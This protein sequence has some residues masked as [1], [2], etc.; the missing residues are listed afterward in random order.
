LKIFQEVDIVED[1][2]IEIRAPQN[3]WRQK[4]KPI[5]SIVVYK[6]WIYCAGAVVE[7]STTKVC[8]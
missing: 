3:S 6:G 1:H 2:K 5:N 8:I 4:N 7:G